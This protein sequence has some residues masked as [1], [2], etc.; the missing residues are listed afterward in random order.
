[1]RNL[2]SCVSPLTIFFRMCPT[3]VFKH[4][5]E[6]TNATLFQGKN[7]NTNIYPTTELEM[8]NFFRIR[9]IMILKHSK[10][11]HTLEK[12]FEN[13]SIDHSY[14]IR[15]R[16]FKILHARAQANINTLTSLLSESYSKQWKLG[17]VATIDELMVGWKSKK[18]D[19]VK[20]NDSKPHP[21]GYLIYFMCARSVYCGKPIVIDLKPLI[22]RKNSSLYSLV[23]EFSDKVIKRNP[24][25]KG[26]FHLISDSAF[27]SKDIIEEL[28]LLGVCMTSSIKNSYERTLWDIIEYGIRGYMNG[29]TLYLT[30][31][32]MFANYLLSS[33]K[34]HVLSTSFILRRKAEKQKKKENL[35]K[36]EISKLTKKIIDHLRKLND[37]KNN[38]NYNINDGSQSNQ[39]R[40][41]LENALTST[42]REIKDFNKR[43]V[44]ISKEIKTINQLESAHN[45]IKRSSSNNR[46]FIV[47]L[48]DGKEKE[49]SIE[50][51]IG[52]DGEVSLSLLKVCEREDL[53]YRFNKLL[54]QQLK[55]ICIT[56]K[57]K[58]GKCLNCTICFYI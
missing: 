3:K 10:E 5:A 17:Q 55:N 21:K 33:R 48:N 44:S 58:Y 42:R 35:L 23:M 18:S 52:F 6:N 24:E 46:K 38:L 49:V 11:N 41:E 7:V 16:R 31:N 50:N 1:M 53:I 57:I 26:F 28:K 15:C 29:R 22:D 39:L 19:I 12:Y 13:P 34:H 32:G 45:V 47:S 43:I 56:L 2:D 4:I 27:G 20:Y 14:W 36:S 51:L 30:H 8:I 9:L 25:Y 54:L 37:I 40:V